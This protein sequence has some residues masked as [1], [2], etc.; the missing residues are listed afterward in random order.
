MCFVKINAHKRICGR[1]TAGH[2]ADFVFPEDIK[3][4]I[5]E[6]ILFNHLWGKPAVCE[7][8]PTDL[9]TH[10]HINVLYQIV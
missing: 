9:N 8:D 3:N 4:T 10:V 2:E 1:A 7:I 5:H 6:G